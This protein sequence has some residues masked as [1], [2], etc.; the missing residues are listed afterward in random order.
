MIIA[1]EPTGN[2]DPKNAEE[3]IRLLLKLNQEGKMIIIA[4][5]DDRLVDTL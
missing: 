3:I 2:L 4:T 1:D 5:H